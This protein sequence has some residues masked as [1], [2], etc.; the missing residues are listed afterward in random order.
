M[1]KN[2]RK[3]RV[4]FF[5]PDQQVTGPAYLL[6]QLRVYSEFIT[7]LRLVPLGPIEIL[8]VA[9]DISQAFS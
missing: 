3:T 9:L 6:L 4:S 5:L 2:R 1:L 8:M 7:A